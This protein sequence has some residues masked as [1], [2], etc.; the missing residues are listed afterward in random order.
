MNLEQMIAWLRVGAKVFAAGK[1]AV[2]AILATLAAHG[3]D[4]ENALLD[5]AAADADRR[6]AL[7]EREASSAATTAPLGVPPS[8]AGE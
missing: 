7:A 2:D 6:K 4:A 8:A 1:P 3:I 5:T